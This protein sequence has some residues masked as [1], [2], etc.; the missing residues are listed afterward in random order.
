MA[1]IGTDFLVFLKANYPEDYGKLASNDVADSIVTAIATKHQAKFDI[2]KKVPER[3]R[4]EYFGRVPDDILERAKTD[5][6]LTID[7][8]RDIENNR[9]IPSPSDILSSDVAEKIVFDAVAI[10][11]IHKRTKDIVQKGYSDGAAVKLAT[12]SAIRTEIANLVKNGLISQ[13]EAKKAHRE[14]RE[15]DFD[16]IKADWAANQ[17]EKL[18]L[19]IA[20]QLDRKQI[21][22]ET[23]LPQMDVLMKRV[24]EKGREADL[25]EA[26]KK[27]GYKILKDDTRV[28]F[29]NLMQS[30]D[31]GVVAHN[32]EKV[33]SKAAS[34]NSKNQA[35]ISVPT[36]ETKNQDSNAQEK[37]S[38]THGT[39]KDQYQ[40]RR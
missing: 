40:A 2:W 28:L 36:V 6:N 30:H 24:K 3:I 12:T 13:E 34:E 10:E 8:C 16:T 1:D 32:L 4:D 11:T 15:K 38:L 29:A 9:A 19:R 23:A 37:A 35:K 25:M 31:M 5:N 22:S 20:K 21:D 33:R 17:P 26:L 7:E 14:T 27:P 39:S 18:L